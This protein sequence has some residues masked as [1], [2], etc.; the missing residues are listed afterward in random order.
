[1]SY[2]G[3]GVTRSTAICLLHLAHEM[4]VKLPSK[5][6]TAILLLFTVCMNVCDVLVQ[7]TSQQYFYA[8]VQFCFPHA[9]MPKQ[10]NYAP[11]QYT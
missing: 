9:I 10:S 2:M 4:A 3:R 5:V 8:L 6:I 11:V 1:M 7:C